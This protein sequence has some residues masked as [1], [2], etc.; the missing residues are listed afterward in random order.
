MKRFFQ[1]VFFLL[2]KEDKKKI[3]V[4]LLY[5]FLTS[6]L[7]ILGI[8]SIGVFLIVLANPQ[9]FLVEHVKIIHIEQENTFIYLLGLLIILS[10][11]VR[12]CVAC[13]LQRKITQFTVNCTLKIKI[14]LMKAYQYAPYIFHIQRNSSDLISRMRQVD[15]LS[16]NILMES[17]T[18]L[19]NFIMTLGISS[20]LLVK[21]PA[22]TFI[23]SLIFSVIIISNNVFSRRTVVN[24]SM[25]LAT[26]NGRI[27]KNIN[28]VLHGLQ[29]IK[30]LGKESYFINQVES[31]V[32]QSYDAS[33]M[34][35]VFSL[36]P[37]YI[38]EAVLAI[39]VIVLCLFSVAIGMDRSECVAFI[40][41]FAAAGVR[42]LP[43]VTQLTSGINQ[44]RINNQIMISICNELKELSLEDQDSAVVS[45]DNK[46]VPF[47]NL[48]L[49]NI[50]F[51]YPN[52]EKDTLTNINLHFKKGQSIALI[53]ASGAGKST[54]ANVILGLFSPQNG[55]ICFNK[56]LVLNSQDWREYIAYIPQTI[57]LL[58]DTIKNN[59]ALGM[60]A[61]DI[62]KRQLNYAI[63]MAQLER[64]VNELPDG[65]ETM[66]GENGIRLSGGQRQRIALARAF[67]YDRDIIVLD[68]AT[69][70]LDYETE[71]EI[72]NS[73]RR[74]QGIKT[75]IIITHR[76]TTIKYCDLVVKIEKGKISC[77]GTYNEIV[78]GVTK[79]PEVVQ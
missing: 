74:L 49:V 23:L 39:F 41:I 48:S 70:A 64:V 9:H 55:Q 34:L 68:E 53:G 40:G 28:H 66:L 69:S 36:L 79:R 16:S 56:Q 47:L 26:I 77:I 11:I 15:N 60:V 14:K 75:L 32:R 29:E 12:G 65:V 52:A 42:L 46:K 5:I 7:D 38:I 62:N 67:Y 50:Y 30:I 24:K 21:Y 63:K 13:L 8:S 18:F 59:I 57:F 37:R 25:I 76:L 71:H 6:F 61:S 58:D 43:V 4:I 33:A 10:F 31:V 51:K 19:A 1:H 78:E 27:I 44:L 3:P 72:I 35:S 54:L 22:P 20:L 73:I 45:N 2:D 17:L